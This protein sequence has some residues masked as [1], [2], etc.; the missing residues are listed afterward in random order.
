MSKEELIEAIIDW[1]K[2]GKQ[3]GNTTPEYLIEVYYN[4][5]KESEEESPYRNCG[6]PKRVED[7]INPIY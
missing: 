1:D 6:V 5:R 4:K 3:L 7:T 2:N